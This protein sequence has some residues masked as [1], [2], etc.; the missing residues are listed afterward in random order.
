MAAKEKDTELDVDMETEADDV[1]AAE[2]IKEI[3]RAHV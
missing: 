2:E 3:G 1:L